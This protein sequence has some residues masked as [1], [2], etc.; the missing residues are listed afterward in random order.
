MHS[1]ATDRRSASK[2]QGKWPDQTRDQAFGLPE[3][4]VAVSTSRLSCKRAG[5][6]RTL[7]PVG[8]HL[9]NLGSP[10]AF[11]DIKHLARSMP[12]DGFE[13]QDVVPPR[14]GCWVAHMAIFSSRDWFLGK[15]HTL[16]RSLCARQHGRDHRMPAGRAGDRM[17]HRSAVRAPQQANGAWRQERR[18]GPDRS[19]AARLNESLLVC[20]SSPERGIPEPIHVWH[21]ALRRLDRPLLNVRI[22]FAH[23]LRRLGLEAYHKPGTSYHS[24]QRTNVRLRPYHHK[25][26]TDADQS[27][28]IPHSHL[29]KYLR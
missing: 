9:E 18:E 27:C 12:A 3:V 19:G 13:A 1:R 26:H 2:C 20:R 21:A 22:L 8:I 11:N 23:S 29:T 25:H 14:C 4:L 17:V 6:T 10:V 7:M 5:K 15:A 28:R 16:A 24:K